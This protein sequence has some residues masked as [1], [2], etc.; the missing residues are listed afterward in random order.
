ALQLDT[1]CIELYEG[2]HLLAAQKGHT[3]AL[4][5]PDA[6]LPTINADKARLLQLLGALVSN[7]VE[8]TKNGTAIEIIA[9]QSKYSVKIS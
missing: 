9:V 6:P 4:H 5:L 1:L 2:F 3:L 8:H 7:A